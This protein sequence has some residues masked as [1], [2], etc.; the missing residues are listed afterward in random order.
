MTDKTV[1]LDW[2]DALKAF[3]IIAILLNHS[4][5]AF[6]SVPW[7]SNPS[8]N[9]PSFAE[10]MSNLF[11]QQGSFPVRM[12]QFLGWLGDMGPGVFIFVSGLTLTISALN[13]PLQ[14]IEFYKKRLIR[15]YPLYIAIHIIIL[16][17]AKLFFNWNIHFLSGYNLFSLLGLRFTNSLFYYLNPSWWFIWLI[18][19]MYFFF[20]FLIYVLKKKGTTYFLISTFL[21]TAIS[22]IAGIFHDTLSVNLFIW[23][24]GLFAGTRLFEF[25]FGMYIGYLIKERNAS[26]TGILNNPKFVLISLATYLTGFICSWTYAGSIISNIL[27]T[28]GLSGIFYSIYKFVFEGTKIKNSIIWIGRNSFSVFLLHQPFVMYFGSKVEG[29]TKALAIGIIILLSFPAGYFIERVTSRLTQFVQDNNE[30]IR[31]FMLGKAGLASIILMF[32]IILTIG[33]LLFLG[34]L[35]NEKYFY[36]L[37]LFQFAALLYYRFIIKPDISADLYRYLDVTIVVTT[38][39]LVLSHTWLPMYFLLSVSSFLILTLFKGLPHWTGIFLTFT[40]LI[41]SIWT[42]EYFFR[43][44]RP[45]EINAWGERPALQIDDETTYSLIPN[46]TTHL[47]YNNYEYYTKTNSF[48]FNSPE[49]QFNSKSTNEIRIMIV[50]DAFSM[51]EGVEYE[52]SYPTLLEKKLSD[53]FP[54]KIIHVINAGVTG[55][56]PNEEEAQVKKFIGIVKPDIVINQLFINEFSDIND[57]AKALQMQIGLIKKKFYKQRLFSGV[58]LPFEINLYINKLLNSKSFNSFCYYKSLTNFYEKKSFLYSDSIITKMNTFFDDMKLLCKNA[59]AEYIVLGVPGQLEVEQ[60]K[61]IEFY[62]YSVNIN[63]TSKFDLDLPLRELNKLCSEKNID[64]IDAKR[65][66]KN[67]NTHPFYFTQ[68]WHWNKNGH[69]AISNLLYDYLKRDKLFVIL[70]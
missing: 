25:T 15:I 26:L 13:K 55:Y 64:Y 54:K 38:A 47:R 39:M 67:Q 21:F 20:P 12:I 49:I 46:K 45:I 36:L 17:V 56:G 44:Y 32:L 50:G 51:P 10:R 33:V 63:D 61:D 7:F 48:G 24:T 70:D 34:I 29:Y 35:E 6:N 62:P 19:Q 40:V 9:W 59:R 31:R 23:M 27:I 53:E 68:S 30:R 22:R 37:C 43:K 18:I 5:E 69:Q 16:I 60:Q 58:M 28:I 42:G 57:N 66:L 65:F 4:V 41:V 3:A 11:P 14:T 8:T 2:V 1:K 52:S